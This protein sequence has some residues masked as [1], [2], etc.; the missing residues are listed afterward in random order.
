MTELLLCPSPEQVV[1]RSILEN[2]QKH[3]NLNLD[4]GDREFLAIIESG[5]NSITNLIIIKKSYR[6]WF[7][8]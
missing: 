7:K 4:S 6:Y 8:G 2:L 1:C 5:T 3:K